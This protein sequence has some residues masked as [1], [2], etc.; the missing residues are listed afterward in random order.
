M[1]PYASR[2]DIAS[3]FVLAMIEYTSESPMLAQ[4]QYVNL[5][6]GK[7][8]LVVD[9]FDVGHVQAIDGRC[10]VYPSS[11]DAD[12]LG[13]YGVLACVKFSELAKSYDKVKAF[14]S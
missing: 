10:C 7:I 5:A 4:Y 1:T 14:H 3:F 8:S 6:M 2:L 9:V 12:V 13:E 11:G